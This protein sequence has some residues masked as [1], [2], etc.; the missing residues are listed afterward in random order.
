M[1]KTKKILTTLIICTCL[2][3][4]SLEIAYATAD[5][6]SALD[7]LLPSREDIPDQFRTVEYQD[8]TLDEDDFIEGR[9]VTYS[10]SFESQV[11]LSLQFTVYE[12]EDSESAKAYIDKIV[13]EIVT[14]D[15][16]REQL[17][18]TEVE[19][20]SA[21]AIIEEDRAETGNS[22][23][24]ANDI[25]MNLEVYNNWDEDTEELLTTYTQLELSIIPEFPSWIILP[26]FIIATLSVILI[27]KKL[28][29]TK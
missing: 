24:A 6:T 7:E 12:F 17:G 2:T 20:P 15:G 10:R 3:L 21:F 1:E 8:E 11:I 23:S 29:H 26:L 16:Y 22:W 28:V 5:N 25:V 27:K 18:Y 13:D 9:S 19:I 14:N 4:S